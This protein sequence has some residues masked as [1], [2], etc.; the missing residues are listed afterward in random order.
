M[1][2][3][4]SN[5][6]IY[7]SGI[8]GTGISSLALLAFQAGHDVS[9]SDARPSDYINYLKKRGISNTHVGVDRDFIN[10]VHTKQPIDWFVYGSAQPMDFPDH[11]EFAFC[12]DNN[13]RMSKRDEF[14]SQLIKDKGL[15]LIAIAGTHGKTT[16]TAMA[17]WAFKSLD[18]PLSYSGGAK[19]KF[20]DVSCF[21]PNSDYFVYEADEFDRNFLSFYPAA[22]LISGIDW[23][24]PDIYPTRETYLEAFIEFIDQSSRTFIWKNDAQQLGTEATERLSVLDNEDP[25]I[26][27]QL[28]LAG[29]VNRLDGWLVANAL[30]LILDRPLDKLVAVLNRFPGVSRRFE[31]LAPNLYTDSAHTPP[32]IKGALQ[33]AHEVAQ[34]KVVVVYEG[35]HN[36]RQHFIKDELKN[37]FKVVKSLYIVPSYLAREDS[38]LELLTPD[39]L[40]KLLSNSVRQKAHASKLDDELKSAIRSHLDNGDLVLCLSA[41]GAGSLDEWLRRE[42]PG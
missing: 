41:G 13:I 38:T 11:P 23:D 1:A 4:L 24:H 20:G 40:L 8:G 35:L 33:M 31:R 29:R 37:L 9:G 32:K 26:D 27:R 17:T 39:K 5:M 18:I 36:L 21:N 34:D 28:K 30:S 16:T 2:D 12:A 3:K 19:L 6:H 42:F 25:E 14:L 7:F 10:S 15:K 22:S